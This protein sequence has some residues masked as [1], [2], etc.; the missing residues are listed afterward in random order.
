MVTAVASIVIVIIATTTATIIIHV[1]ITPAS[2][3]AENTALNCTAAAKY[4]SKLLQ[5]NSGG[6]LEIVTQKLWGKV[7][8]CYTK[9]LGEGWN[10]RRLHQWYSLAAHNHKRYRCLRRHGC[11]QCCHN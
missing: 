8:N 4:L 5:T 6:R 10:V 7:A 9:T 3:A 1:H 11:W 2:F